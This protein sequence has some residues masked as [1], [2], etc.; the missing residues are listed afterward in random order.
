MVI[1]FL[2][3]TAELGLRAKKIIIN[4]K[5][6]NGISKSKS[7][8]RG[9][10]CTDAKPYHV[11]ANEIDLSATKVTLGIGAV[12]ISAKSADHNSTWIVTGAESR[13]QRFPRELYRQTRL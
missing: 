11:A 3:N 12:H 5:V 7:K 13:L 6:D 9:I 10:G 8:R 1:S 2:D 4:G